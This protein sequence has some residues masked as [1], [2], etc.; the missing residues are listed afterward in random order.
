MSWSVTLFRKY[1][2]TVLCLLTGFEITAIRKLCRSDCYYC[3]L[4][5]VDLPHP[6]FITWGYA[7]PGSCQ[8]HA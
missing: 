3:F 5:G 6:L 1:I 8:L 7:S 2:K 4:R